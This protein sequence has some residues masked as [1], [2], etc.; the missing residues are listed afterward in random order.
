[1]KDFPQPLPTPTLGN[2]KDLPTITEERSGL[3][4]DDEWS[5]ILTTE[6]KPK[7]RKDP[8][9]ISFI[10]SFIRCKNISQASAEAGLIYSKGYGIRHK[11]DIAACIQKIIDKSAMKYG[12]DASETMERAKEMVDFDPVVLY[13]VDGT[14]KNNLH[15]IPAEARRV[16]K[17]M[18]VKNM[19]G[20]SEDRN[21]VKT[22]IIVGEV[23]EYEFYDKLKAIELTGREK[24]LFK[25]TTKVEHTVSN[26]MASFLLE[27]RERGAKASLAFSGS[28]KIVDAIAT[29][30]QESS[31]DT[32]T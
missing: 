27:A 15:D 11:P 7:H 9:I 20:E 31:D 21:G 29:P 19:W 32:E 6:L 10:E 26:E 30:V 17:K 24:D 4:T 2:E 22:K 5:V 8:Q 23:I 1:M 28:G 18:K 13:N 25:N 14:F 3:L 12:F 16:I